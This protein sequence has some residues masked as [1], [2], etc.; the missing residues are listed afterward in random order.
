MSTMVESPH[1]KNLHPQ[2]GM[3]QGMTEDHSEY[4][5]TSHPISGGTNM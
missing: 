3:Y 1:R 5:A 2:K 4:A